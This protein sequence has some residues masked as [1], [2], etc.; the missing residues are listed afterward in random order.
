M[1]YLEAQ[2]LYDRIKDIVI[3]SPVK[4]RIIESL[5]I[6]PTGWEEM[7]VFLNLRIQKGDEAALIEFSNLGNSLSVYGVSVTMID[8]HTPRWNMTNLD[9]FELI[10]SN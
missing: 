7:H 3:G 2:T 4:G 10:L 6:A 8:R 5:L 9:D 1:N